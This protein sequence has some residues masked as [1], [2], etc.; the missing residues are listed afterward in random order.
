M[1]T[2]TTNMIKPTGAFV[3]LETPITIRITSALQRVFNK[4]STDKHFLEIVL[5]ADGFVV[6]QIQLIQSPNTTFDES[7]CCAKKLQPASKVFVN[8]EK[9]HLIQWV[10][11][12]RNLN[13]TKFSL[14]PDSHS[15]LIYTTSIILISYSPPSSFSSGQQP[16]NAM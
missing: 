8:T 7:C 12:P 5:V 16:V 10:M 15:H 9:T 11:R 4:F 1:S 13:E 14:R 6:H 3:I 2:K